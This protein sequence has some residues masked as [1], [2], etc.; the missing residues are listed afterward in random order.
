M[1]VSAA[2][3]VISTSTSPHLSPLLEP[4]DGRITN[5]NLPGH[6]QSHG[7]AGAFSWPPRFFRREPISKNWEN[8]AWVT[9]HVE[10]KPSEEPGEVMYLTPEDPGEED[11]IFFLVTEDNWAAD[12]SRVAPLV[13]F[14]QRATLEELQQGH[15]CSPTD[16]VAILIDGNI[17]ENEVHPRQYL[18]SLSAL[19][20]L[21]E[22][23]KRV[24]CTRLL[25]EANFRLAYNQY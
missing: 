21:R 4:R 8:T 13:A 14:L 6:G 23:R 25:S 11:P 16:N 10:T 19:G 15:S 24:S 22:L 20:L 5:E 3:P 1:G 12:K 2:G 18:G 9:A 7:Q 17:S